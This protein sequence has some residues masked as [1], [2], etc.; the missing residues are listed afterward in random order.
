MLKFLQKYFKKSNSVS[1]YSSALINDYLRGIGSCDGY[2]ETVISEQSTLYKNVAPL[3]TAI[4]KISNEFKGIN[5]YLENLITGEFTS[6]SPIINLLKNPNVDTTQKELMRQISSLFEIHGNVYLV[7]SALNEVSEPKEL[8]VISPIDITIHENQTDGYPD[9]YNYNS[10]AG[11]LTFYRREFKDKFRY[12]TIDGMRELWH[13]KNFGVDNIKLE[14]FSKIN[15]I[16]YKCRQ[17]LL[18]GMHNMSMLERGARISLLVSMDGNISSDQREKIKAELNNK[19]TGAENSG[20]MMLLTGGTMNV[21]EMSQSNKDMDFINLE[22]QSEKSIYSK[23]EIPLPL[24][25]TDKQTF[26][27]YR[28]A[29]NVFYNS[30]I[31]PLADKIYEELSIFLFPRYKIDVSKFSLGYNKSEIS[32]LETQTLSNLKILKDTDILTRDELRSLVGYGKTTDGDV[33][34]IP[35]NLIP[36]GTTIP[37]SQKKIREYLSRQKNVDGSKSFSDEDIEDAIERS[38]DALS[39]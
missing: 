13:I 24:V 19:Y 25:Q 34:Y 18:G 15:S 32:G 14:G 20:K 22:L 28:Q 3:A 16:Y 27:N 11:V 9:Y 37:D 36:A 26:D 35:A 21:K 31:L 6:D 10:C 1:R 4:D 12:F 2:Y 33:L 17:W 39:K 5:P 38:N 7:A 30:V 29:V 23:Y 8:T